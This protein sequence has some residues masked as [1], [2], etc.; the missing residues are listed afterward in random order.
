MISHFLNLLKSQLPP[1]QFYL[2][3]VNTVIAQKTPS[4][5]VMMKGGGICLGA[6]YNNNSWSQYWEG[7]SLR[8]NGNIGTLTTHSVSG[9][10]QL[11]IIDRI[12]L[13]AM[14]FLM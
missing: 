14:R 1:L 5:E 8:E 3:T 6:S 9:G 13:I 4:D 10:L 7:D 11:G 2:F 12:N